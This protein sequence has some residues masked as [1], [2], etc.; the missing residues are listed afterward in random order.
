MQI[1]VHVVRAFCINEVGGNLAGIV[2]DAENI[3]NEQRLAIAGKLGFSETAF[4]ERSTI[5]DF[6]VRFFTPTDEIDLCGHA[7]LAVYAVLFRIGRIG[8]GCYTQELKVGMLNIEVR[9]DGSIF[10]EQ[11]LPQFLDQ[12]SVEKLQVCVYTKLLFLQFPAQI[13]STGVPDILCQVPS[14]EALNDLQ[15]DYMRLAELNRT[16]QSI[17][18]HAFVFHPVTSSYTAN[19][20][21]FAPLYGINE[22]SAT[23]SANGALACYLFQYGAL[24]DRPLSNLKFLQGESL[25][26]PSEILVNL[27]ARNNEITSVWVGGQTKLDETIHVEI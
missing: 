2:L 24:N 4:V 6:K 3:S 27:T 22:E 19:V 8:I 23:G 16:T 10:M 18:L 13:V 20:R 12:I 17:G 5:A 11:R 1:S 14:L 25:G 7:T 21:N 9:S 15:V 26:L